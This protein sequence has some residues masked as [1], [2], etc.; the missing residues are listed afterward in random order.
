M[1]GILSKNKKGFTFFNDCKCGGRLKSSGRSGC[2]N[3]II[4]TPI[5]K[6]D[7]ATY[8]QLEQLQNG[9][10]PTWNSPDI[11]TNFLRPFSLMT[12]AKVIVR[13]ISP[14]TSAINAMVHYYTSRFG[15]GMPKEL[16]LTKMFSMRPSSEMELSFPLNQ[17][18]L[19][20]DPREGVHILIEH[21]FDEFQINNSGSQVIDCRYTSEMGRNFK[22]DIPVLNDSVFSREF[23]FSIM[24]TDLLVSIN[25]ASHIFSPHEQ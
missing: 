14:T 6:P 9:N 25:S 11:S 8:S 22:L 19:N 10:V 13:N 21:P 20:G 18:S 15:I 12:E 2:N 17:S 5:E 3:I 4:N 24:Q 23:K 1:V 7:L 16:K